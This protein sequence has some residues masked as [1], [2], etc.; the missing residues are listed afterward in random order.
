MGFEKIGIDGKVGIGWEDD[1]DNE[2]FD[3]WR[4]DEM[5]CSGGV[6]YE[7]VKVMKVELEEKIS[8]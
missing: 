8:F 3:C 1:Y 4:G 5:R 6:L 7:W 2:G